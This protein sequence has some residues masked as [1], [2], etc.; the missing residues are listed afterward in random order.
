[1]SRRTNDE[2]ILRYLENSD[3]EL[4]YCSDSSLDPFHAS[5]EDDPDYEVPQ[6]NRHDSGSSD[7]ET[8]ENINRFIQYSQPQHMHVLEEL[9]LPQNDSDQRD[10]DDLPMNIAVT[11]S[12][13][14][15]GAVGVCSFNGYTW[16][17][18]GADETIENLDK[19]GS[20]V[21]KLCRNLLGAS[22]L[23]VADNFY[24]S[25]PLATYLL[26]NQTDLCGTLRKNRKHL[27][28]YVKAKKLTTG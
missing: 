26:A 16:K 21:V 17:Y 7:N 13:R 6:D 24:T 23:I 20:I 3:E 8:L 1:M 28:E 12:H 2:D 9:F 11:K 14:K 22:R 15:S 25:F 19:P 5:D 18:C 27:P 4:D 10:F